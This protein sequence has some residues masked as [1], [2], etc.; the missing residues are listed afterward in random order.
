MLINYTC[1]ITLLIVYISDA[2]CFNFKPKNQNEIY[3]TASNFKPVNDFWFWKNNCLLEFKLDQTDIWPWNYYTEL[4]FFYVEF[5]RTS[6][7]DREAE[8]HGFGFGF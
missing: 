6:C 5:N 8:N 2:G 4:L 7:C 3:K 1:S